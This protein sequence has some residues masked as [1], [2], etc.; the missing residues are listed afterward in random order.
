MKSPST[1]SS[2]YALE[3]RSLCKEFLDFRAICDFNLKIRRRD[4]HALIGPNGA[5]KT[6]MFIS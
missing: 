2:D 6:M 5:G 1:Q 4:I 3:K